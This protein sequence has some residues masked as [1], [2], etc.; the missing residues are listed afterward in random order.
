MFVENLLAQ[1]LWHKTVLSFLSWLVLGVLLFGRWRFGW[2]GPRAVKLTLTSMLLLLL[3][4]FGSKFV[5][6]MLLQRG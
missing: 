1:H 4:Y 3:A 6:E 2:R 5:L